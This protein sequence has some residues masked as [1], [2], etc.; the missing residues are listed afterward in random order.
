MNVELLE[1]VKQHIL[2]E[3]K[4]LR[5]GFVHATGDWVADLTNPPSCGTVGCIAGWTCV[6]GN[7]PMRNGQR[8]H[9]SQARDLLNITEEQGDRLFFNAPE[10]YTDVWKD[11]GSEA[12]AKLCAERIDLFIATNGAE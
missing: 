12:T 10:G 8:Y 11:D 5:M 1:R 7:A 2:E 6:L 3:P 9:S 4:R